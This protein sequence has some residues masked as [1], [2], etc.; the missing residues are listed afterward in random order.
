MQKSR[1]WE[2]VVIALLLGLASFIFVITTDDE[3]FKN[4]L[5]VGMVIYGLGLF[6]LLGILV[7]IVR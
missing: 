3:D 4:G 6:L 2:G 7:L 5:N 1:F